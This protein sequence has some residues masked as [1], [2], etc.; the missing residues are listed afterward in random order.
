[1]K[2]TLKFLPLFLIVIFAY[3]CSSGTGEGLDA[4]K[5]ELEKLKSESNELAESIK[6]LENEI[7]VLDPEFAKQGQKTILITTANTKKG[8]FEHFVEV[9]RDF[10]G[11]HIRRIRVDLVQFDLVGSD[12]AF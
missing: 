7:A 2:P 5:A 4:K 6:E 1:M 9:T 10:G 12:F 8:N 11:I 3:S